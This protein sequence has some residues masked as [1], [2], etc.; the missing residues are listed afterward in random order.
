[1]GASAIGCFDNDDALDW[2][3]ELS[4]SSD[5]ELIARSLNPEEVEGYYLDAPAGAHGQARGEPS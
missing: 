3:S 4:D 1:M 2:L 5:L